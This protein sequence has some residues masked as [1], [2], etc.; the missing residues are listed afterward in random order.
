M[1]TSQWWKRRRPR[2]AALAVA[3]I[4]ALTVAGPVAEAGAVPPTLP[5]PAV[6]ALADAGTLT[7]LDLSQLP[8]P[9]S[10][11]LYAHAGAAIRDVL[12]GGTTVC[13]STGPSACSTNAAP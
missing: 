6:Q 5:A 13:V 1:L 9:G 3:M 8:I 12:N 11:F 7:G 4:A 10:G 2:C